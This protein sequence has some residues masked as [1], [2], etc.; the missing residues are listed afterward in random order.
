MA[1]VADLRRIVRD[2]VAAY[3][4]RTGVRDWWREPLLVTAPAD[5]RFGQL[6]RIAAPDHLLPADLLPG[7]RSVIVYFIP[8]QRALAAAN[9]PGEFP[10]R[11]WGLAYHQTNAMIAAINERL[12]A[13]LG[14]QG[15]AAAVTPA[16]ANFD[17]VR[18]VSRWSHKHLGHLAGLGRFGVNCQLITPAGCTGRLG[19]LVTTAD[20][21]DHP[22]VS[23][24]EHCL[25]RRGLAC[26]A[27]ARRC[28]AGALSAEGFDRQ[29]CYAR[30]ELAETQPEF[31]GLPMPS[32]VCAKCQV[33]LPCSFEAPAA[34]R[35]EAERA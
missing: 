1:A 25:H 23:A 2:F 35:G 30:L 34:G 19:S 10:C 27:C 32:H 28:P 9:R 21:G 3:P 18:L 31:E 26:L 4:A 29:A 22:L 5:G 6:P 7:A 15:H 16:T 12:A 13:W 20:L 17:P 8:F 24:A 33:M 11:D 14:E